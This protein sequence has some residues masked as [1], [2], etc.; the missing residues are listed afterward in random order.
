MYFA[1]RTHLTGGSQIINVRRA[2]EARA[3]T[4]PRPSWAAMI[5]KAVALTA[6]DQPE[7]RRAF[8]PL[9]WGHLYEHPHSVIMLPLEREF[10][11][12]PAIF[13]HPVDRPEASTLAALTCTIRALMTH[14][15]EN[16]GAFRRLIRV[17]RYPLVLRRALWALGLYGC[18]AVRSKYFG[19]FAINPALSRGTDILYAP[20]PL[21]FMLYYSTVDSTGRMELTIFFDHRVIDGLPV[22][23]ALI[24]IGAALNGKI[25]AEL[26]AMAAAQ[27]A[28]PGDAIPDAA[29]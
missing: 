29:K 10:A 3:A 24:E 22:R 9:P 17:S 21:S 1:R 18:G 4:N 19:T 16:I 15:I 8:M 7:L 25:A 2:K 28:R 12:G 5:T 14:P 26:D 23:R 13:M 27:P 20:S 11:G 6:I